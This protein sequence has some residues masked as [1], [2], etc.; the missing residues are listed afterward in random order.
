MVK[1]KRKFEMNLHP[2]DA[3]LRNLKY[4]DLQKE[5]VIRG[6]PFELVAGQDIPSL[7]SFFRKHFHDPSNH[8]LLNQ[9]DDWIES[10]IKDQLDARGDDDRSLLH[11]S[12]RLGY[13]GEKDEEGNTKK[14]RVRTTVKKKKKKRERTNDNVFKGTKKALAFELQGIGKSKKEVIKEVK[15]KFPDANEKSIGIW[16]NKARKQRRISNHPINWKK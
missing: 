5:C 15:E 13:I 1:K 16:F 9:Y 3:H 7:S 8:E 4:R 11:P 14:K 12:L 6:M 2:A 10:K